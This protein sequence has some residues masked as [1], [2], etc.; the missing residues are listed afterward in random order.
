MSFTHHSFRRGQLATA[1]LFCALGFQYATWVSRIPALKSGLGLNAAEVGILLMAAGVGACAAFP[2]VA[3]LM[4]RLGSRRLAL[5]STVALAAVLVALAA[6]PTYPVALVVVC[7]DG[8]VVGC[9]NTAMNAQGAALE[10]HHKRRT[11]AKLHAVFSG[12]SFLAGL[13]ASG[14][15]LVTSSLLAHFTVAAALLLL[16]A[17][18]AGT[19][20]LADTEEAPSTQDGDD[21][22]AAP[23]GPRTVLVGV[24]G[25]MCCA[26]M[27]GTVVEGAM[28]DWSALYLE[29][30]AGASEKV[31]PLGITV[32]AGM[33]VLARLRADSWR[34]RWG[35]GRVV[36]V[37]SGLAGVGL[38]LAL[39][40]GGIVPAFLGF[41]CVGLGVAAVTPCVYVAAAHHGGK[42]LTLVAAMGTTGLL[43]GPPLIGFVAGASSLVWGLACVAAAA[44]AVALCSTRIEWR[45]PEPA[46][47]PSERADA[48]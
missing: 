22:V 24:V 32:V 2:L 34:E 4:D 3:F 41:A 27:F 44:L 14:M 1:A 48:G 45:A 37:G 47:Q 15:H 8:V 35:D 29:D 25:W 40:A 23:A 5:G 33:M 36:L 17:A 30:V 26:M 31:A 18:G 6:A 39:V 16:L 28:N 42:A 43:A 19:G 9:L 10:A 21:T 38:A 13:L 11:M 7:V 20:L 12:G 46:P